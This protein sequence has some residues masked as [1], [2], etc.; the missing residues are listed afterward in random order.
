[1]DF[2]TDRDTGPEGDPSLADMTRTALN[3][4]QKSSKGFF[5]FVEAQKEGLL[6]SRNQQK[7][8]HRTKRD[9][10]IKTTRVNEPL[11]TK[12]YRKD[13]LNR[14]QIADRKKREKSKEPFR[15]DSIRKHKTHG[16]SFYLAE[17]SVSED[18]QPSLRKDKHENRQTDTGEGWSSREVQFKKESGQRLKEANTQTKSWADSGRKSRHVAHFKMEVNQS[19]N[20]CFKGSKGS[21]PTQRGRTFERNPSWSQVDQRKDLIA[22]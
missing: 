21:V 14:K 13:Y 5:L 7:S 6:L 17:L 18:S 16:K 10:Y 12:K 2:E 15:P 8:A 9:K 3:V 19:L 4:L 1:M 20:I 11:S 22:N